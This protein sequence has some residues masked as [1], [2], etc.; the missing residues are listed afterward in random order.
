MPVSKR[1]REGAEALADVIR[2][3][4]GRDRFPAAKVIVPAPLVEPLTAP[5]PASP[6]SVSIADPLTGPIPAPPSSP[7]AKH[8]RQVFVP[9]YAVK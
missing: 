9:G 5:R 7:A 2:C 3:T 8:G 1:R 6:E 4:P